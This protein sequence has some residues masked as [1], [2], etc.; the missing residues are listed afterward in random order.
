[1][2][3]DLRA[4]SGPR[5]G[6]QHILEEHPLQYGAALLISDIVEGEDGILPIHVEAGSRHAQIERALALV[7]PHGDR[8]FLNI[9]AAPS[10]AVQDGLNRP[11]SLA[12][13]R[14]PAS[15]VSLSPVNAVEGFAGPHSQKFV[16][17]RCPAAGKAS[18]WPPQSGGIHSG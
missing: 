14:R 16:L 1:M 12:K 10:L 7:R 17:G 3:E 9:L 5:R 13:Q 6:V 2:Q 4:H 8:T 15:T 18:G 11:A